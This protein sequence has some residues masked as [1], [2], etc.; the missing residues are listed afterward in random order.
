MIA[1]RL[2]GHLNV[3]AGSH[4]EQLLAAQPQALT[5]EE[6]EDLAGASD[7]ADPLRQGLSFLT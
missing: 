4:G 7:L 1:E 3:Y 6:M 2:A 5:R